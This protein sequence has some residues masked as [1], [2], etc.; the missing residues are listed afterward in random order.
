MIMMNK[1]VLITGAS[2]GIGAACALLFAEQGYRVIVHYHKNEA[3]AKEVCEKIEKRGGVCMCVC[4][5]VGD[6]SQV[7]AM[8]LEA[9]RFGGVDVLVNNAG[10]AQ[11]AMLCDITPEMWREVFS[12]NV[13]GVYN[14]CRA[15]LSHMLK[16]KSGRII[17][18]SSMWGIT[19]ASCETAYSAAKA[20]VIGFTKA[21]AKELGPSN[22]TV[23]CVAPGLV[24]T[25][26]NAHLSEEDL[27]AFCEEIPL[28]CAGTPAQIAS[29]VCYLATEEAGYITGQVISPNG[30]CVI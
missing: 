19:G 28:G 2:G 13:D 3:G 18:I 16:N 11:T 21:L 15:S 30:G 29:T 6:A 1:T 4:A 25:K 23:N 27:A 5:D 10:I 8:L 9:E 14:C 17:N 7:E 24:D 20:A 26:M 12:V 22:I